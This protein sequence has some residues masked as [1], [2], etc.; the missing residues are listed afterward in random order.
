MHVQACN[1][2]VQSTVCQPQL[3]H[4]CIVH[5][6]VSW[7]RRARCGRT[8]AFSVDEQLLLKSSLAA[9]HLLKTGYTKRGHADLMWQ[10]KLRGP[11]SSP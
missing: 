7:R 6:R 1:C 2:R 11:S 9:A 5:P 8:T 4:A 10:C 3:S